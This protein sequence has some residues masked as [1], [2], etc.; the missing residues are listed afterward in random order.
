VQRRARHRKETGLGI[1]DLQPQANPATH[2][3]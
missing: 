1:G 2:E 3:F